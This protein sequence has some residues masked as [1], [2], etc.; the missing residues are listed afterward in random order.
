VWDQPELRGGDQPSEAGGRAL[1]DAHVTLSTSLLDARPQAL[2][3][4]PHES[5]YPFLLAT[6]LLVLFF[7][8]LSGFLI[9]IGVGA[10]FGIASIVGWLWPR[11]QTQET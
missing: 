2:I 8:L 3:H 4:M 10:L 5:G 1:D 7:G 6:S 9:V 11:G